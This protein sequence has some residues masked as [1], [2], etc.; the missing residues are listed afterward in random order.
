MGAQLTEEQ[1][2]R[3]RCRRAAVA[4]LLVAGVSAAVFT[5]AF[6]C[7]GAPKKPKNCPPPGSGELDGVRFLELVTG[8]ANPNAKLPMVVALHGRGGT[9]EIMRK[10]VDD[11]D[12]PARVIIPEGF[13]PLGPNR[14][15]WKTRAKGDQAELAVNMRAAAD[16]FASFL[17]TIP[18]CRKTR[19]KPVVAGHS[20]GGMMALGLA[21]L[22]P[23]AMSSVV[24]GSAWI[25]EG[26][27]R[28]GMA[29]TALVHGNQDEI[30]P[31]ARTAAMVPAVNALGNRWT[32]DTVTHGHLPSG[33][34]KA[35]WLARIAEAVDRT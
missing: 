26:L 22:H 24:A 32:L 33:P 16:R 11:L 34:L 28:S 13:E 2:A 6:P 17:R 15:W 12:V 4:G 9:P 10:V 19:G 8:G 7:E 31:Y 21:A 14:M 3:R 1:E 23:K 35:Q 25:P 30:V 29:R 20:Q 27:W 5:F 18:L